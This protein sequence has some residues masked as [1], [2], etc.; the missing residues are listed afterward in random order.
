MHSAIYIHLES[1][2]A[3]KAGKHSTMPWLWSVSNSYG[4][5]NDTLVK[6]KMKKENFNYFD[7]ANLCDY[8]EFN[9]MK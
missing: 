9:L 7:S 8:L 4:A 1:K 3:L 6:V 5:K 2:F